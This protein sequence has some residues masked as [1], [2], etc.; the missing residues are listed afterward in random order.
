MKINSLKKLIR[1]QSTKLRIKGSTVSFNKD[2]ILLE[3]SI[4]NDLR[5]SKT[6]F[7]IVKNLLV[8][9]GFKLDDVRM[10]TTR[11]SIYS[12]YVISEATLVGYEDEDL[13]DE[14]VPDDTI[15]DEDVYGD[16]DDTIESEITS[17]MDDEAYLAYVETDGVSA[18][19]IIPD[20]EDN[21]E[22]VLADDIDELETDITDGGEIKTIDIN[23]DNGIG[24]ISERKNRRNSKRRR[25]MIKESVDDSDYS[26]LKNIVEQRVID[27]LLEEYSEQDLAEYARIFKKLDDYVEANDI[28]TEKFDYYFPIDYAD[29]FITYF[30][31]YKKFVRNRRNSKRR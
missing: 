21:I 25:K 18:S 20:D 12:K 14:L 1:E 30:D 24:S 15:N 11:N 17:D 2:G 9:E 31:D 26:Y 28:D 4:N 3:T 13:E 23:K 16:G 27:K 22:I 8:Q 5:K 29:D 19:N 7:N 6:L 10:D